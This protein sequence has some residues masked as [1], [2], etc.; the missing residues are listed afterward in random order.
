MFVPSVFLFALVSFISL[1]VVSLLT[2][3]GLSVVL[4]LLFFFPSA[5]V[6][7]ALGFVYVLDNDHDWV[8]RGSANLDQINSIN[9]TQNSYH[10]HRTGRL[11]ARRVDHL[12]PTENEG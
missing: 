12:P 5:S 3:F 9:Q 6:S 1:V 10:V 4:F 2:L 8:P 11:A 7:V